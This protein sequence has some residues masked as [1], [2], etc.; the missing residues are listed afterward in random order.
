[1]FKFIGNKVGKKSIESIR[2]NLEEAKQAQKQNKLP[3]SLKLYHQC[4]EDL[5]NICK[6]NPSQAVKE[7]LAS[8]YVCYGDVLKA[9]GKNEDANTN[10]Y[11][12]KNLGY[13]PLD[14]KLSEEQRPH[15]KPNKESKEDKLDVNMPTQQVWDTL[16]L[17]QLL[18]SEERKNG[19][20][21]QHDRK[22]ALE[23]INQFAHN[24]NKNTRDFINE[25]V[26]FALVT[27]KEI[28][29]QLLDHL[30][31]AISGKDNVFSHTS[32]VVGLAKVIQKSNPD[33]LSADDMVQI[34]KVLTVQMNNVHK[35]DDKKL[36][37]FVRAISILLDAMVDANVTGLR[38]V[39]QHDLLHD[40]LGRLTHNELGQLDSNRKARLIYQVKYARQALFRIPNDESKLYAVLRRVLKLAMGAA[41]VVAAVQLVSPMY[42]INGLAQFKEALKVQLRQ[43]DWYE[44]LR[45]IELLLRS[46]QIEVFKNFLEV[47]EGPA[48]E[49]F[50]WRVLE[51]LRE[52]INT[53]E[54]LSVR[55]Q[56]LGFVEKIFLDEKHWGNHL[57]VQTKAVKILNFYQRDVN[58]ELRKTAEAIL[59]NLK[60]KAD[61]KKLKVITAHPFDLNKP[62]RKLKASKVFPTRL[63]EDAKQKL[64][65]NSI[66]APVHADPETM[67]ANR[68]EEHR[69]TVLEDTEIKEELSTYIPVNGAH[70]ITDQTVFNLEEEIRKFLTS[71][72][73]TLLLQGG[74]G[75]GKSLFNRYLERRLWEAY[76]PGDKIP[77]FISLPSFF[78]HEQDLLNEHF[79][80]HN[81]K[82]DEINIL[83]KKYTFILILDGYDEMLKFI[84]LSKLNKFDTRH[85]VVITCRS[86]HISNKNYRSYFIPH[87][88]DSFK[89]NDPF[90]EMTVVPFSKDQIDNYV[91][92]Y[93][94]IHQQGE[95]VPDS[96]AP[97]SN[98]KWRTAETYLDYFQKIP[99]LRELIKTPFLLMIA[100]KVMPSLISQY[101]QEAEKR[102]TPPNITP[103]Y[104]Y[105]AFIKQWFLREEEILM[106]A[107]SNP[108]D[109]SDI[110]ET[111]LEFCMELAKEIRKQDKGT[112]ALYVPPR[113]PL[114]DSSVTS[115]WEKFF[116]NRNPRDPWALALRAAPLRRQAIQGGGTCYEFR[117]AALL[118]YF[119]TRKNP[120]RSNEFQFPAAPAPVAE[121]ENELKVDSSSAPLAVRQGIFATTVT[122]NQLS[123]DAAQLQP[124]SSK[125]VLSL[126]S[127]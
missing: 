18:N 83:K 59:Q 108:E 99:T 56:A 10:Y 17:V 88:Y 121:K 116:G 98:P 66:A 5:Q 73:N 43:K 12:A 34:L 113:Q 82:E 41:G 122:Q 96:K 115:P 62:R 92:K 60:S 105:D 81:F 21:H 53:R 69:K 57:P 119:F 55:Q 61:A 39:E 54:E 14:Q 44:A 95:Q 71:D 90:V 94:K 32:L 4:V 79:R 106:R 114:S 76:K 110:K 91:K 86:D 48:E 63:L 77:L 16:Q 22:L 6:D 64:W 31:T 30:V 13:I 103:A 72:N 35:Q 46:D 101:E 97:H 125:A 19:V 124:S 120:E 47:V 24:K 85:K 123:Q 107:G 52:R 67:L 102:G 109:G 112:G 45:Y 38:R 118:G 68:I 93:L 126:T 23:I 29:R 33:M 2:E 11:K 36:Y 51:L 84:N 70:R 75:G 20:Y 111:F 78:N 74:A 1:M 49:T 15:L 58:P 7:L 127:S 50:A 40:T 26:E 28:H 104:L 25:V 87:G 27:D 3:L 37:F 89:N 8:A 9:S 100:M 80:R 42:L 65:P 117:H